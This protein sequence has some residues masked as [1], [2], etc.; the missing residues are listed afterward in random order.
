MV[1]FR[2][3][4]MRFSVSWRKIASVLA[5]MFLGGSLLL[6]AQTV[7][8][9]QSDQIQNPGV[10]KQE[11]NRIELFEDSLLT[12][13]NCYTTFARLI[14]DYHFCRSLSENAP[15]SVTNLP[16][17]SARF[18]VF[19]PTGFPEQ[20]VSGLIAEPYQHHAYVYR[21]IVGEDVNTREL[22]FYNAIGEELYRQAEE[23]EDMLDQLQAGI[24][25]RSPKTGQVAK[26]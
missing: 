15:V 25:S 6:C 11:L 10:S 3:G 8:D 23:G 5:A 9:R 12:P 24:L 18:R 17:A 7:S 14:G 22:V 20:V 21:L 1:R 16:F 2:F 13:W 26:M 4:N 19:D